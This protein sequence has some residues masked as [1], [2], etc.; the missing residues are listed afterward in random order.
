MKA[1]S[2]MVLGTS[3]GAGKSVVTAGI[4]RLLSDWGVKVAP[5]KAQNMSNN[6]YVTED[7]GEIGRAQAVQ[8]ECARVKPSVHMNPVL[9][10]PAADN[11][12]Q[13]VVHGKAIGH[14]T[15]REF[16]A[17]KPKFAEAIR[18][19]YEWMASHYDVLIMEGAGSPA[20]INLK[21]N[22]L[23]NMKMAEMADASCVLVGDIDRGGV[24]ASLIG[25]LELLD[26]SERKRI[27]GF[28]I[29]KFRGD[30]SLL[31]DGLKYLQDRTGIPVWGVLPCD[32]DLRIEEE[33]AL[34]VEEKQSAPDAFE[35]LDIAVIHLPR[36]SNFTDFDPIA[37]ERGVRVRFVARPEHLGQPDLIILP[38][39]KATLADYDYLVNHGF[40]QPLLEYVRGGGCLLGICGGYQMMGRRIVDPSGMDSIAG[41]K[42]GFGFLDMTTE[43]KPEKIVRRTSDNLSVAL[44][45]G[46]VKGRI[47]GY[48]IHMGRTL[49][50]APYAALGEGGA[51]HASGRIA[52]SYY[53]G[54]FDNPEFR[55][56]FLESL[57]RLRGKYRGPLEAGLTRRAQSEA[58]YNRLAAL[59]SRH[60]DLQALYQCLQLSP[61]SSSTV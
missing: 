42:E 39:T 6:S 41:D 43:F 30:A 46:S 19:S 52:G 9:L 4:C 28:V 36:L 5:F 17:Q 55:C 24:F 27:R 37:A 26:E 50:H 59:L 38:G 11:G 35:G 49:H 45:G 23:V 44:F 56:S 54:L 47:E 31:D 7:G 32:R 57:A 22:D 3:S 33:D 2:L 14:F 16:Y 15:A 40:R 13:A 61:H 58:Q 8:A 29:N 60:L 25:T 10:K 51:V 48:E 1:R 12:S 53:H 34:R 21:N 20:E 18:E